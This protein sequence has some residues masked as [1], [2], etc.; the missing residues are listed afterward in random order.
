MQKQLA[1][2]CPSLVIIFSQLQTDVWSY[3]VLLWEIFTLGDDPHKNIH[4]PQKLAEYYQHGGRLKKPVF[5]PD[6]V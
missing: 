4:S 2:F 6:N 5:M 1:G 3:G